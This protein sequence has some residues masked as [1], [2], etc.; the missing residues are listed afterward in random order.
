MQEPMIT[1]PTGETKYSEH[2]DALVISVRIANARI[3]RIMVDSRSF[4]DVLYFD[5]FWKLVLA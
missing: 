5:T 3:K 1:I 4:V 2:D